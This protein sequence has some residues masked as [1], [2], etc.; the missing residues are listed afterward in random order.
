MRGSVE[1]YQ[2]NYFHN[3]CDGKGPTLTVVQSEHEQIFGGYTSVPWS[4]N[5]AYYPDLSAFLFQLNKMTLHFPY[6]NKECAVRH[7][8][9]CLTTFGGGF[10]FGTDNDLYISEACDRYRNSYCNLGE[11]YSLGQRTMQYGSDEARRYMAGTYKF[12]VREMEVFRV[13]FID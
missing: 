1:G 5:I 12:L 10:G 3:V 6:R 9:G 7:H 13:N 8:S 11:T 2:S 4:R